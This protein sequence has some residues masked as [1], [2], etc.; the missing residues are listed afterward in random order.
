MDSDEIK[1]KRKDG[2][3]E[4]WFAIEA[5]AVDKETT[6]A[7]LKNHAE[8][9]SN[10]KDTLVYETKFSEAT[11]VENP[12][13]NVKEGY[14]QVVEVKLFVKNIY[15]MINVVVLY[16]PS[17]IEILGPAKKEA[18]LD[19]LQSLCNLLSGLLHQFAAQ[20]AGGIVISPGK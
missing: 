12:L 17:S 2:W 4:A 5:L 8:K 7:A 1:K 16:G 3:I 18:K 11:R 10:A 15:A 13:P 6:V 20:G 14:S 19:E 9:L